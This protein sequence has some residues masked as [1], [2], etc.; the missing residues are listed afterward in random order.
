M[1]IL[2]VE[3]GLPPKSLALPLHTAQTVPP[4]AGAIVLQQQV[5]MLHQ[6]P[7]KTERDLIAQ[8]CGPPVANHYWK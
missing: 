2:D 6:Q 5:G 7:A 4:L 1:A 3:E 8:Y